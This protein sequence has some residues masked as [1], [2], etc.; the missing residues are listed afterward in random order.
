MDIPNRNYSADVKIFNR[1]LLERLYL[2]APMALLENP[3]LYIDIKRVRAV[4]TKR[5][6]AL[7]VSVHY[8]YV[9]YIMT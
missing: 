4:Y 5:K 8:T 2:D 3:G 1:V 7:E 9:Y 6:A